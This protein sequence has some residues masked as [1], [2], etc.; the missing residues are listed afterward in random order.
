MSPVLSLGKQQCVC[1]LIWPCYMALCPRVSENRGSLLTKVQHPSVSQ[2]QSNPHSGTQS[3]C[4]CPRDLYCQG[5]SASILSAMTP[6]LIP[7]AAGLMP[8]FIRHRA[9]F[10]FKP[11]KPLL[12]LL[13]VPALVPAVGHEASCN[14]L[15]SKPTEAS[16]VRDLLSF[17]LPSGGVCKGVTNL[18][19]RA[20]FLVMVTGTSV[21]FQVPRV[22]MGQAE[23]CG[24]DSRQG[25][26]CCSV[27]HEIHL[28]RG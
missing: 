14:I 24:A 28:H 7:P 25:G 15:Q 2:S 23:K 10:A 20:R 6:G 4:C 26:L 12:V 5:Y 9:G 22:G 18:P 17:C 1:A 21:L 3:W 11:R 16:R 19:G 27:C 8:A 13:V